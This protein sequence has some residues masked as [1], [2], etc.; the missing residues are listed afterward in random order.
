[1]FKVKRK[2]VQKDR[3]FKKEGKIVFIV[4]IDISYCLI[5]QKNIA[6]MKTYNVLCQC[7]TIHGDKY[8]VHRGNIRK[9]KTT[10]LLLLI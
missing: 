5:C 7:I 8:Y 10:E 1:M 4:G 3:G 2:I 9:E 6:V